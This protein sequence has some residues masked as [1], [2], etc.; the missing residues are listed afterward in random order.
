MGN[1]VGHVSNVTIPEL[2]E[3]VLQYWRSVDQGLGDRIA[4]G[5]A[6]PVRLAAAKSVVVPMAPVPKIG[7]TTGM[8]L[9]TPAI[10]LNKKMLPTLT[11][12]ALSIPSATKYVTA[13][14]K[15]S[16]NVEIIHALS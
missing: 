13:R 2:R 14:I 6:P 5:L 4:A 1:V 15:D 11:P 8:K 3:R 9:V 16:S 12:N 10:T 7:P